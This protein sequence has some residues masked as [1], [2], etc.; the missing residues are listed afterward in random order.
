LQT[1]LFALVVVGVCAY[2]VY[3]MVTLSTAV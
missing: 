3:R 2:G 1:R